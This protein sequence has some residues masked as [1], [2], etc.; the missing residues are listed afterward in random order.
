MLNGKKNK[1]VMLICVLR[2]KVK[3]LK[4]EL[5][6]NVY[7][8]RIIFSIFFLKRLKWNILPPQKVLP[9]IR[10]ARRN[11]VYAIF[12]NVTI[13]KRRQKQIYKKLTNAQN[14]EGWK[15]QS[16]ILRWSDR[17]FAFN[18]KKESDLIFSTFDILNTQFLKKNVLFLIS[19]LMP[20]G[21]KLR[22]PS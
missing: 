20:Q 17:N 6:N 16:M 4:R 11:R 12:T 2:T 10:H 19:K 7:I 5:K 9:S 8:K 13:L 18:Q 22:F 1:K 21:H 15:P 14:S 3:K